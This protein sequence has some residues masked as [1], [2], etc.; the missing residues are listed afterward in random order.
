MDNPIICITGHE[1]MPIFIKEE[2]YTPRVILVGG[3]SGVSPSLMETL[4]KAEITARDIDYDWM[5]P[6]P[7]QDDF[8]PESDCKLDHGERTNYKLKDQPFYMRGRNGK[9][10]GY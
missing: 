5:G 10:R 2:I 9:M 3:D 4:M 6:D 7:I 8:I 1:S